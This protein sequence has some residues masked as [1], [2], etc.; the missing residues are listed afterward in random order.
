MLEPNFISI[1]KLS[2]NNQNPMLHQQKMFYNALDV[3][4]DCLLQLITSLVILL[5]GSAPNITVSSI[6]SYQLVIETFCLNI[7]LISVGK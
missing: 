5:K 1:T 6:L 3:F 4:C 7:S 2:K